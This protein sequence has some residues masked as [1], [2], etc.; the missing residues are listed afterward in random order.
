MR[1]T[2]L[3]A[4]VAFA[5]LAVPACSVDTA[6][7]PLRATPPGTGPTI[8]FDV[9]HKPLPDI[10][11]PNDIATVADPTSR[12]G[13]RL[14]ASAVAP[15][16]MERQARAEFDE[17]EGWGTFA[18][19]FVRFSHGPNDDPTQP[20][21]DLVN[22]QQRMAKDGYDFANDVAYVINLKTGVPIL[23]DAGQ[24]NFNLSVTDNS[25]YWANDY[26]I[27]TQNLLFE[28]HEEGAGLTQADYTPALDQ[29]FDGVLDHPNT[30]GAP[31]RPDLDGVDNLI[32]WYERE[33]D[34]LLLRPILPM[35]EKT[36]Y[37]V[38]L[39]DRLV[40]QGGQ[41]ARSPFAGVYHPEQREGVAR[42]RDV[43]NDPAHAA[44]FGDIAGTGLDHVSFA[45]TFTTEP[46]QEDL[47]LLRD[48]FYGQG[49]FS[50]L[51]GQY[52]PKVDVFRAAG[53]ALQEVDE[54]DGWQS[55]SQ[56]A[57]V[58]QTPYVVHISDGRQ[59]LHDFFV[60]IGHFAENQVDQL[61]SSLDNVDY[62]VLGTFDVPSFLGDPQS[63]NPYDH[64]QVD[65]RSGKAT[66]HQDKVPFWLSV[67]K[68]TAQHPAPF[69][70]SFWRHGTGQ[71]NIEVVL[72]SGHFAEQGVALFGI[73]APGHSLVLDQGKQLLARAFLSQ[74][75]IVPFLN[76]IT[77]GRA[78]DLNGDGVPDPAGLLFSAH[79]LHSRDEIR[80][81]AVE[82]YQ[83]MRVL[84]SF[85]GQASSGVDY[86]G[87]GKIDLAGDFNGDGAVDVGGPNV[88]YYTS[89]DSF[90]GIMA[91]I[92]AG[93]DPFITAA[94]PISGGGGL[95]DIGE[96]S[97][98][99]PAS[100]MEQVLSPLVVAV[101]AEDRPPDTD[102]PLT[103]CTAGQRSVRFVLNNLTSTEEMEIACLTQ[104]ELDEQMTVVVTNLATKERRCAR[105]GGGGRFR[106]AIP[107][108]I[109]DGID[110]Q[111]FTKPD[112]VDSYATCNLPADAAAG[113]EIKTWE[114]AATRFGQV[115]GDQTCDKGK[116]CQQFRDVFYD[117]GTP[118]I[119]PM[120]GVGYGRDTPDYR[121]F[122]NLAQAAVDPADPINYAAYYMMKPLIGVDGKPA[123]TRAL[124]DIHD[125]GDPLV[126]TG[127]GNAFARAAGAIPFLPQGF[128][129]KYPEYADWA[130]PPS[131]AAAWGGRS[132]NDVMIGDA[133]FEGEARFARFP[134]TNCGVNYAPSMACTQAPS[135]D[136][137]ICKNSLFDVDFIGEGAQL[138]GQQHE[139]VPLR[140]ARK[141][142]VVAS[143]GTDATSR[144]ALLASSWQ[145]RANAAPFSDDA[146]G[147]KPQGKL[148]SVVNAY[149]A[150]QGQHVW[151]L[152]DPCRAFDEV[153]YM[154]T[155]LAHFLGTG[156]TDLYYLSHPSSHRCMATDSCR[157]Q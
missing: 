58:A 4:T 78:I 152:G 105:T 87:D 140:L 111:V 118:L 88:A 66:I 144:D 24:G 120:E 57:H 90:G 136:A 83:G 62:F 5:A 112:V 82:A 76:G 67:P 125:L 137:T 124:L 71:S 121:R 143:A 142:D 41:P 141:A 65:Y 43:L 28:T 72:H 157:W 154:E 75:C 99:V 106:I 19:I 26:H 35:E 69:P 63:T 11:A 113:R 107:T 150:P 2:V 84:R 15:T 68:A 110:I 134:A 126:P 13:R 25:L 77:A 127:T 73:M 39:T 79:I 122:L 47:H 38:V 156:G 151:V 155:L 135:P 128:G 138:Y 48:G 104:Q 30:L 70:V 18:P 119:A 130:T 29:D 34:T 53:M 101:P 20:A 97:S 108:S 61:L 40:G 64:F 95:L 54:P 94:A 91:M 123:P 103:Q 3:A 31:V 59:V 74:A 22:V 33:T 8:V 49:P 60:D 42:V 81:G 32:T 50:Y 16:F 86:N 10:P 36:E 23:L 132:P 117:V 153:T 89:G 96:R 46:V 93:T 148:I 129:D 145:P 115:D 100:V 133:I 149:M 146:A 27:G 102:G 92:Q 139:M 21:I 37:A 55:Q 44:Y 51:Q 109:G 52:P 56:C 14:N 131:L 98:L 85:D 114:Q 7:V 6:P 147:W 9:A 12:T 116:Q 45:W 80:Q 1:A 17:L